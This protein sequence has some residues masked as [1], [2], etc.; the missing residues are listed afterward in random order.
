MYAAAVA[1]LSPPYA[2]HSIHKPHRIWILILLLALSASLSAEWGSLVDFGP[3]FFPKFSALSLFSLYA[4]AWWRP[5][6]IVIHTLSLGLSTVC[7]KCL[8]R[9]EAKQS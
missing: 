3:F 1:T 2:L 4:R 8:G 5:H 9:T 6:N 7:E